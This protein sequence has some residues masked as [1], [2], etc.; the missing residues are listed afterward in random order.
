MQFWAKQVIFYG[1]FICTIAA[2]EWCIHK[3][4]FMSTT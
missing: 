2:N 1:K 4:V 3:D